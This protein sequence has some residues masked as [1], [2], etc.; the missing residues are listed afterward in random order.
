MRV[1]YRP[2]VDHLRPGRSHGQKLVPALM[3]ALPSGPH[4][5]AILLVSLRVRCVTAQTVSKLGHYL[6]AAGDSQ[7]GV[8]SP[9]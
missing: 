4:V 1:P 9:E 3:P 2:R 5:V 7:T 6:V 8:R